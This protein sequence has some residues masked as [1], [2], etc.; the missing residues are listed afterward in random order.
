M[1][2]NDGRLTAQDKQNV[3]NWLNRHGFSV[4][5]GCP[6]CNDSKWIIGDHVVSPML[7]TGD[8]V[9]IGGGSYP[10]VMVISQTCGYTLYL[11]AILC[12]VVSAQPAQTSELNA[13]PSAPPGER[14]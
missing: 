10:Q 6:V 4:R 12:G 8:S 11:N 9:M 5:G 14:R 3:A 1:P 2:S 13:P 7:F